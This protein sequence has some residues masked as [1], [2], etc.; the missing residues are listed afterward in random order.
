MIQ[1]TCPN[2]GDPHVANDAAAGKLVSCQTCGQKI[3]LP[4]LQKIPVATLARKPSKV[5]ISPTV[6]LVLA[7]PFLVFIGWLVINSLDVFG[8]ESGLTISLVCIGYGLF[9]IILPAYAASFLGRRC[10]LGAFPA[11]V[12]GAL[13]NWFGF[14][15]V[16][17]AYAVSG[18]TDTNTAGKR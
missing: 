1:A 10:D 13:F 17:L 4:A 8:K 14:L 5:T 18:S 3:Q 11:F 7:T 2:C 9:G 16:L 12:L 15:M 6:F